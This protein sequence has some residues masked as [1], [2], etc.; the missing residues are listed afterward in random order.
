M[1]TNRMLLRF[2]S[3]PIYKQYLVK[4]ALS[5]ALPCLFA[6]PDLFIECDTGNYAT[7]ASSHWGIGVI[8]SIIGALVALVCIPVA[9]V[10]VLLAAVSS[11]KAWRVQ[12]DA[13]SRSG[14][15]E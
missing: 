13:S 9:A 8:S 5:F 6:L 4:A 11:W 3:F 10:F 12:V 14:R 1:M 15:E 7:C 2:R